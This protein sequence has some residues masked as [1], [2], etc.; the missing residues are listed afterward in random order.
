VLVESARTTAMLFFILIGALVVSNLVNVAGLPAEMT[1]WVK[2]LDV[3]PIVVLFVIVGL[4][5]FLGSFLES[6]SMILL[7]VPIFFPIVTALGYDPVW[8]GIIVVVITEIGLIHPPLGLN[9]FVLTSLLP[10]IPASEIFK[11]L[12]P[13]L[14]ADL[15]RLLLMIFFPIIT[16]ILP[17]MM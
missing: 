13:F 1:A 5:L 8:F 9:V 10:E 11:G 14:I 7:T 17:N 4:Y 16:L 3:A 15:L 2:S 12:I 6:V